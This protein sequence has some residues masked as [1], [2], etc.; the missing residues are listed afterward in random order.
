MRSS[1]LGFC[2]VLTAVAAHG[3][4]ASTPSKSYVLRRGEGE[5]LFEGGVIIKASPRSGTRGAEMIWE[6]M[7]PGRSTG[8]HVHHHADEFFYVIAGKG[9]VLAGKND[10]AIGAGDVIFVAK[11]Q[12]HRVKNADPLQPLEIVFLVDKPGLASEFRA[13]HVQF[14]VAKK[15]VTL[16]DLNKIAEK[17]GTTYKTLK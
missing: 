11:G 14:G 10:V 5:S 17:Y 12:D 7:P 9:M 3:Q 15:Q 2:L 4:Q 6:A 1:V 8:V 16:E 13:S